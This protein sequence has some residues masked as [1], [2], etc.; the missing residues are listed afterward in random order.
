MPAT[1]GNANELTSAIESLRAIIKDDELERR[2]PSGPAAVYT[3]MVT[4]WMMVIG[5]VM[6]MVLANL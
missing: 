5:Q 6:I 2:Q 4:I 3:T 1:E